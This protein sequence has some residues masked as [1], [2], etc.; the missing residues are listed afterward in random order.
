MLNNNSTTSH[1]ADMAGHGT[2]AHDTGIRFTTPMGQVANLNPYEYFHSLGIDLQGFTLRFL[3]HPRKNGVALTCEA[4]ISGII[5][6]VGA[7]DYDTLLA[8]VLD[9]YL[10]HRA[11]IARR[12]E[13][14][15]TRCSQRFID[16]YPDATVLP[17]YLS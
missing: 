5:Y 3:E 2:S 8:E 12:Q 11:S 16:R 15:A 1:A 9:D 4:N 7:A 10:R 6:T 17:A 13:C 14:K